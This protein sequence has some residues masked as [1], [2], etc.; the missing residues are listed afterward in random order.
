VEIAG[1]EEV[2]VF[3][4]VVIRISDEGEIRPSAL[5]QCTCLIGAAVNRSAGCKPTSRKPSATRGDYSRRLPSGAE[6]PN[7]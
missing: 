5:K 2:F 7:K 4:C 1:V 3:V 6:V